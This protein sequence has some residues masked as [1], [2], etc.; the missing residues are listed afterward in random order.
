VIR[1]DTHL[2]SMATNAGAGASRQLASAAKATSYMKVRA[3]RAA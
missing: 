1:T 3:V 2:F